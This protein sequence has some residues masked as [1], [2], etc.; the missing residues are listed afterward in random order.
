MTAWFLLSTI[1]RERTRCYPRLSWKDNA[2]IPDAA[3]ADLSMKFGMLDK[4]G[5]QCGTRKKESRSFDRGNVNLEKRLLGNGRSL[6]KKSPV[7]LSDSIR[8]LGHSVPA[9][10]HERAH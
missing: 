3:C 5:E 2:D 10:W 6:G 9:L 1:E 7:C 4:L 8:G